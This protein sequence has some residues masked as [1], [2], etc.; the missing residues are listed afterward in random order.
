MS[1]PGIPFLK[2][3]HRDA[4]E[5]LQMLAIH[6][7]FGHKRYHRDELVPQLERFAGSFARLLFAV[8]LDIDGAVAEAWGGGRNALLVGL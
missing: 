5:S 6:T 8:S 1:P 2:E 3:L 4:G 7:S